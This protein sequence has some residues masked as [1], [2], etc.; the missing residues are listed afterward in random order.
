MATLLQFTAGNFLSFCD[1]KTFSMKASSIQ[2]EPR[3]NVVVQNRYKLLRTAAVYGANSSGK[4]N[5]VRAFDV[6]GEMVIGSIKLNDTDQL[7][8]QP[9][10]LSDETKD[11]PTHFEVVYMEDNKRVRYGFEYTLTNITGEWLFIKEGAAAEKLLFIRNHEG[12]GIADA[13]FPEGRALEEKTNDNRLFLSLVAQL[14]GAMSKQ[15]MKW[16][17]GGCN[18]ISGLDSSGYAGYTKRMFL[19]KEAKCE[20]AVAFFEKLQL[21]FREVTT[22]IREFDANTIENAPDEIKEM[23]RGGKQLE[24]FT[25]HNVYNKTGKII[26]EEVFNLDKNES[27]GTNKIFELSGPIFDTLTRG[28]VLIV[29]ELDAKMHPLISHYI[30][31]LFNDP[32]TNP[33]HAQ[34]IFTTHDT[35]LLSSKLLRRDQV[36]FT[37]KDEQER[38]DLYTIMDIRLPDGTKP[39]NDSNYEKNYINGRYGA[40]PYIVN[41]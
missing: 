4:S 37:E 9:F 3:S 11:A 17:N 15:V 12:I 20:E 13:D 30:V 10:L 7:N 22:E 25:K 33:R 26:G 2:D 24:V 18:V 41:F 21:G 14:G 35:H 5:L 32:E 16:F 19:K 6:M 8:Y 39:R 38:T 40:I 23:L 36:W 1:K 27:A 28:S 34:L 29:D 31:D